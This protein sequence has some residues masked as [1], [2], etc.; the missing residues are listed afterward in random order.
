MISWCLVLALSA[1]LTQ[2]AFSQN[3]AVFAS[4]RLPKAVKHTMSTDVGCDSEKY[5]GQWAMSSWNGTYSLFDDGRCTVVDPGNP[6]NHTGIWFLAY[7]R[8]Y[9]VWSW[10]P[11]VDVFQLN[12]DNHTVLKRIDHDLKNVTFQKKI[13]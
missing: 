1:A 5:V 6:G 3:T 4:G 9:L 7:D 13:D 12:P 10:G 11:V 2:E 8:L